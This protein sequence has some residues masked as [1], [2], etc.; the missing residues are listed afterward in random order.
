VQDES[1]DS[2]EDDCILA[3]HSH[4]GLITFPGGI[5]IRLGDTIIGAI[6]VSGSSV[7]HDHTLAAAGAATIS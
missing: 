2:T 3:D 5:P 4:G 6:G 7:E 1:L